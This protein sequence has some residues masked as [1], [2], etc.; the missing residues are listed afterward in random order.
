[1]A[2]NFAV[3]TGK[4]LEAILWIAKQRPGIDFYHV[5]KC[6]FYADKYHLN[7]YGRPI[8][9]DNYIA[10]TYGP[11]GRTVYGLLTNEPFEILAL[12]GNGDLPFKVIG[13]YQIKASR[14]PNLRRLSE[15][16]VESLRFALETYGDKSF[17]ELFV[18][19]HR[20]QAYVAAEGGSMRYENLLD[21]NDPRRD[22]KIEYLEEIAPSAVF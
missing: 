19:S 1:M 14:D 22:E 10:D 21:P 13:Q 11:L 20:D 17:D 8:A 15:S 9:G 12:G 7:K 18:E 16:D 6:C 4:A 2:V 5:V 3:N